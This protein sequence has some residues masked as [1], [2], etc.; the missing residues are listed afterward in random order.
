[1]NDPLSFSL[2]SCLT[3]FSV[4]LNADGIIQ[5]ASEQSQTFLD[6]TASPAGEPVSHFV[7]PEDLAVFQ[8]A[9]ELAVLTGAKR[10]FVC[11]LLRQR[12][13]P[14]WADC[15]ILCL[16]DSGDYILLAFDASHW[17]ENEAR[18]THLSTHDL[19]T[20][21]PSRTLL[22]DRIRMGINSSS[23]EKKGLVLFLLD[24]D[25]FKKVNDSLGHSLGD[26]LIKA[27]AERIQGL[28]RRTDTLSRIGGDEFALIMTITGQNKQ[29]D[30]EVVANKILALTQRPFQIEGN[31]LYISVS[32]G[33]SIYMEH[34]DDPSLLLKQAEI[35]M[36]SAK[37]Q[38]KNRWEIY[39]P[40]IDSTEKGGLS[41]EAAMHEGVLNGEFL[42]HYQPVFCARTGVLKGAEALMR[43]DRPGHS[44]V[45]PSRFIPLAESS[46]LIEI[47]G[48]WA[49]R[50]ACHQA[51]LW[52]TAG[53]TDFY[54][55]VNV[56]PSQ[57]RRTDF[58][59]LVGK[60]LAE[61]GLAPSTLMLEITEGVLMQD[62]EKSGA[63]LSSLRDLGVK[64]AIDD[65][66]TGYSS[67]AYL[68]KFP[69]SVLKIDKSFVDDVP[70]CTQDVAIVS[71]VLSLAAGLN[72][73]V[74]A[75]GVEVA[76]Q[77]EFLKTKGCDLIQGYLTGKPMSV[78]D[79]QKNCIP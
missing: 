62:P 73:A 74:V 5:Q 39:S 55:S 60:A 67:L 18:L 53:I 9:Q 27:I 12:A 79:F 44:L 25:G 29:K 46:G 75:E 6:L 51:M 11:R 34:G 48:A 3:D 45:S 13:L 19:L 7:L 17:K 24:L 49:L 57:F 8:D 4:R 33:A 70:N 26:K 23:R 32:I 42:L 52:Q 54:V 14:V 68:K 71:A 61:S 21:L 10:S 69:L 47:L 15:H 56:S 35:A 50:M 31:D 43:W 41:L 1:M 22:D 37:E 30:V 78:A 66:G 58:F 65:F 40:Q 59:D 38:G 76:E 16:P 63:I 72:L 36:Y 28:I 20:G 77:L 64:I 2:L